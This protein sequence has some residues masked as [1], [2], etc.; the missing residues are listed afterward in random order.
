M[1]K[2]EFFLKQILMSISKIENYMKG[3]EFEDFQENSEKQDA[4]EKQIETIGGA[5]KNISDK[6]KK[7][8]KQVPWREIAGMRD[9]IVHDYWH[10]D[11]EIVW[12]VVGQD[13]PKLEEQ[14]KEILESSGKKVE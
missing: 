11:I 4:V 2:D 12:R 6:M 1:L 13:L 9:K 10:T 3:V 7:R 5:A 8:Y 14:A